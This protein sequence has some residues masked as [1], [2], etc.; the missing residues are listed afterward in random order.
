MQIVFTKLT[1]QG[2]KG[3]TEPRTIEFNPQLTQIYGA[4]KTGKTTIADAVQ[5]VLFGKNSEGASVFGIKTRTA[6]GVVIPKLD[7]VVEL[8]ML[9]D[10]TEVVLK[11]CLK[12]VWSKPKQQEDEV[13]SGHETLVYVNG[14][15]YT[16]GDYN[17]YIAS[18]CSEGLFRCITNPAYFPNLKPDEQRTLLSKMV[19]GA[20]PMEQLAAGKAEF[21]RLLEDMGGKQM[22]EYLQHIKYRKDEIKTELEQLPARISEQQNDIQKL[23]ELNLNYAELEQQL[24][25]KEHELEV[26]DGEITDSSKVVD[27]SYNERAAKR[28]SINNLRTEVQRMEFAAKDEQRANERTRDNAIAEAKSKVQGIM[29]KVQEQEDAMA[30]AERILARVENDTQEFRMRWAEVD[31]MEFTGA[32]CPTCGRA[33]EGEQLEAAKQEFNTNK[34]N[35]LQQLTA[36]ADGIKKRKQGAEQT[37][38]QALAA[39][40]ELESQLEAAKQ[41]LAQ[42]EAV[43]CQTA[44]EV[45]AANSEYKHLKERIEAE[46]RELEQPADSEQLEAQRNVDV[47]KAEKKRLQAERDELRD[48]LGVRKQVASKEERIKELEQQI[49]TLN[50]QLAGL[51]GKEDVAQ[52]FNELCI[53]DLESKVNALFEHV[54]FTMFEH[55]LNGN[56]KPTC[57]CTVG[58]VPYSDLNNADKVNAGIDIINAIS[59]YNDVYVPCFI[60]NAESINEVMPMQS[61]AVH[62]IVSRDKELKVIN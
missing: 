49:K 20:T 36:E 30:S 61:Q 34:S 53:E 42:A 24:A 26:K 27:R 21:E 10:G 5:W 51:E 23:Q 54:R 35:R 52:R 43:T 56:L 6:D 8:A 14:D 31:G 2:F 47:L 13:L 37:K 33:Y 62:L 41:E 45:L 3:V 9:V 57:E 22:E 46:T 25:H 16:V 44:S 17:K 19:G 12:E 28:T 40:Q 32:A 29:R 48:K 1:M 7:H 50:Q 11:R 15:K 58:G 18:L 55:K 39:K 59:R 4:N 60:D 38:Q